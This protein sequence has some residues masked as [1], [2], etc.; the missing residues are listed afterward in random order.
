MDL[1]HALLL[2]AI[3]GVTEFLP[4]S[5]TGHLILTRHL[6]GIQQDALAA[7]LFDILIQ[8]GTWVAVLIYYRQDVV[9][10]TK[11]T[12]GAIRGKPGPQARLGWL[13]LLATLPAVV[14]GWLLKGSIIGDLNGLFLT[15]VF[16]IGNTLLLLL[17]EYVDRRPRAGRTLNEA[18]A[19]TIGGF[20]VLALLPA[21]SRSAATLAGGMVRNLTRPDAARFAFLMAIPIMPAAA[22]VAFLDLGS[23]PNAQGLLLPLLAGFL[24]ATVVGYFAIRWLLGYLSHRSTWP[25]AIYCLIAGL[26]TIAVSLVL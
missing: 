22:V 13:L 9:A 25:F 18:D 15:G 7:S 11:D 20:Q 17:A 16:L 6:F 19:L 2:G 10:I 21:I 3:Q 14:I 8:L 1:I 5:S 4:I 12:W 24:A 23:L 26:L